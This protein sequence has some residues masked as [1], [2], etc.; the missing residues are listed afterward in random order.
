MD[1]EAEVYDVAV[2]GGGAAGLSAAR[3]RL[4]TRGCVHRAALDGAH[5]SQRDQRHRG[6]RRRLL[7]RAG[8]REPTDRSDTAGRLRDHVGPNDEKRPTGG[9]EA[10]PTGVQDLPPVRLVGNAGR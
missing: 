4:R 6:A 9:G 2:V 3:P 1:L 7:R 10:A 8:R 5:R